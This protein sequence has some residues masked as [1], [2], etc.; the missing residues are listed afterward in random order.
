MTLSVGT[1]A[2]RPFN[3]CKTCGALNVVNTP[4]ERRDEQGMCDSRDWIDI[5]PPAPPWAPEAGS[6]WRLV[7]TPEPE[8]VGREIEIERV[9]Y[10]DW[11]TEQG[12]PIPRCYQKDKLGVWINADDLQRMYEEIA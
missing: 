10:L 12:Q 4:H 8:L 7:K 11:Y 1:S 5:R 3:R 2:A 9:E 6:R